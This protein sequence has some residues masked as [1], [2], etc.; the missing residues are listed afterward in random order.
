MTVGGFVGEFLL[1]FALLPCLERVV[2]GIPSSSFGIV[3]LQ[4]MLVEIDR[5]IGRGCG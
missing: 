2:V 4:G 5:F 1:K 3:A